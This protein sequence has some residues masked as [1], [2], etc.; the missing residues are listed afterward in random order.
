[1]TAET[2]PSKVRQAISAASEDFIGISRVSP[3]SPKGTSHHSKVV[4]RGR[5]YR[6]TASRAGFSNLV[7]NCSRK[8]GSLEELVASRTVRLLHVLVSPSFARQA[9]YC[10]G[11]GELEAAASIQSAP[12]GELNCTG[13][14][15]F[16]VAGSGTT[17]GTQ[18]SS[19][20]EWWPTK[21]EDPQFVREEM[22]SVASRRSPKSLVLPLP[23]TSAVSRRSVRQSLL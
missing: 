22:A 23:S 2:T 10:P 20:S 13:K 6:P 18:R 8:S 1:M 16:P 11:A 12:C 14:I 3:Y 5:C 7:F 21:R 4:S 9:G 19:L 17:L 15:D